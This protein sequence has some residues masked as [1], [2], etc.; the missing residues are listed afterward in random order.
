VG[1]LWG[2]NYVGS[3]EAASYL[4]APVG[5]IGDVYR[6]LGEFSMFYIGAVIGVA[7]LLVERRLQNVAPIVRTPIN[8]VALIL[9]M[10]IYYGNIF[11]LGPFAIFVFLIFA[12]NIIALIFRSNSRFRLS[13]T[14]LYGR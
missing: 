10:Y 3:Q 6:N 5:V 14:I 9:S 2:G 7:F 12:P 4:V 1:V 11:S 13:K 8:F